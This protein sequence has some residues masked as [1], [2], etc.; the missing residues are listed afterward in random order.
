[1]LLEARE[2]HKLFQ[3]C[4]THLLDSAE[5]HVIVHQR[6][7]L[8]GFLVG[9]AQSPAN[10]LSHAHADFDVMVETNAV[11]GLR[12]GLERR[13]LPDIMEQGSPSQCRRR[14]FGKSL[15]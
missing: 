8:L 12:R 11:A 14:I 15:K 1:M 10:G 3:R 7:D 5:L 9:E 6:K 4:G 2:P 13:W